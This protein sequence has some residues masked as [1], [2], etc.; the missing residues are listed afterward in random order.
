MK[1]NVLKGA[2]GKALKKT[3]ANRFKQVDYKLLSEPFRL[4]NENDGAWRC[5][6]W[7]KVIRPAITCAYMTDDQQL[8]KIIDESV[9]DILG[10]QTP[11]GCISSYPYELQLKDWDIWG[12]KYSLL[13]LIRYY[14][15]LN[16][17]PAILEACCRA[18]DYFISQVGPDKKDILACGLHTGLAA[19]SILGAVVSMWRLT[20]EERFR[21]FAQ[22][23]ISRGCSS[24]G[25]I[26]ECCDLGIIPAALGNSKAYEMTSCFQG[27]A[28]F[29]L[30]G[31]DQKLKD[32]AVKY[33]NAVLEH[34]IFVTGSG[35]AR[36]GFGE[37]WYDGA[38]RQTR[39]DCGA[40][41]ET[42]V[43]VT[44]M[45]YCSRLLQLTGDSRFADE[46]EKSLYNSLLGAWG[47]D[48]SNWIHANPTPLT[49]GGYKTYADDQI[50]RGFGK[51][52]GGND[53]CRAQGPEGFAVASEIAVM[54]SGNTVTVNLFEALDSGSLRIRGEYP[55]EPY[56]EITFNDSEDKILRLRTPSFLK[57]I[58]VNGSF[59]EFK[60]GS[61]FEFSHKAGA[62]DIIELGFDFTLQEVLSP[63]GLG[64]VAVK[65]G[66][67]VLAEDSRGRVSDALVN[68]VWRGRE[69][70]EY[71]AAGN[72]ID[73]QNTL[74]VWFRS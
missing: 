9:A 24:F 27:A 4:R 67:L 17:D 46:I 64:F 59:V 34:E 53:C 26:F 16:H 14:E 41:G 39:G 38:M 13:G 30:V 23:I 5:E 60:H 71:A 61:Y 37:F 65:R 69:L 29:A 10:S 54:E 52:F 18:L 36:D 63:D 45:R 43:T 68:E 42:C 28:E 72:L 32:I 35:G 56:A 12:R 31:N 73:R 15:L 51:P 33:G 21:R 7:G 20:G 1:K 66:P 48:G 25:N 11:D 22:Y 50:G 74:T 3:I 62:E 8:K 44:W 55:V 57:K 70:C 19:S 58:K 6:F 47:T 49:G 2:A 40:L